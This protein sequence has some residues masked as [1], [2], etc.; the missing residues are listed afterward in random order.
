[1]HATTYQLF[2]P[3]TVTLNTRTH[4]PTQH[5]PPVQAA[6]NLLTTQ[7]QRREHQVFNNPYL[8]HHGTTPQSIHKEYR[9]AIQSSTQSR[10]LGAAHLCQCLR[11][12]GMFPT[13]PMAPGLVGLVCVHCEVL[14]GWRLTSILGS[15]CLDRYVR[16]GTPP[17]ITWGNP[18]G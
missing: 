4:C 5:M 7:A 16:Y 1:M 8:K 17:T 6:T 2:R 18:R 12:H 9:Q 10:F 3:C 14:Q 13:H 15:L 11:V